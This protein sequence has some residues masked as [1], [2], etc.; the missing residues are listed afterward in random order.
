MITGKGDLGKQRIDLKIKSEVK[1][2]IVLL[3]RKETKELEKGETT[4]EPCLPI[5]TPRLVTNA[6]NQ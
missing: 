5:A 6:V 1:R 3:M 4:K 2:E